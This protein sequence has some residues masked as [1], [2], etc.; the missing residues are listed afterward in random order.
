MKIRRLLVTLIGIIPGLMLPPGARAGEIV[1]VAHP[2]VP[3]LDRQTVARIYTGK[4]V[5]LDGLRV[6]PID[7]PVGDPTRTRFLTRWVNKDDANYVAYWTVRR[8]VGKGSPPVVAHGIAEMQGIIAERPGCIGYA[9][10]AELKPGT[11]IVGR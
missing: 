5:E 10:E 6:C 2:S 1:I 8:Y 3:R 11:H 7:L 4:V 9:D